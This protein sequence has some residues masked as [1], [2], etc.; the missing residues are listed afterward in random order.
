[1]KHY[2]SIDPCTIGYL[3]LIILQLKLLYKITERKE[4]LEF[5][6]RFKSYDKLP[7]IL[8]MYTVKYKALKKLNRL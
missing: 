4:L 8:R 7:N 6:D 1:M 2:P 3:R 5:I